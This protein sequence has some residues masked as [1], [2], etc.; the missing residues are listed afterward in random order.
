MLT[1]RLTEVTEA[2][3]QNLYDDKTPESASL[4]F[5]QELPSATPEGR[6][7]QMKDVCAL[8]NADG[9]DLIYGIAEVK[10]TASKL[11]PITSEKPDAARRRMTSVLDLIEPRIQG[12]QIQ[13]LESSSAGFFLM[14]RV[15][16][17][18]NGPHSSLRDDHLR[19]FVMRNG[20]STT[21][22]SMDQIRTAFD[23]TASL[24]DRARSFI[25]GRLALIAERKTWRPLPAGPI[26]TAIWV[27]LSGVAGR[28]SIDIA[29]LSNT[30]NQLAF[31]EWRS[32]SRTMNLDGLVVFPGGTRDEVGVGFT[33]VFRTGPMLAVRSAARLA[34]AGTSIPSTVV[35]KFY[36]EAIAKFSKESNRLGLSGP[37]IVKCALMHVDGY[38]LGVGGDWDGYVAS[39]DRPDISLPEAW[40]DAIEN[41]TTD[42]QINAIV[43]P[44]MDVL[45]QAF[46]VERCHEFALDGAWQPR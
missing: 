38:T 17:S 4:E 13:P 22:M 14:V 7:E 43:Q 27:P 24:A 39:A 28:T 9:G 29:A 5:K 16:A 3:L 8:A 36:R 31:Q 44:M 25:D 40:V 23:R 10:A 12:I 1:L 6:L 33:Q 41:V 26:A 37:A 18:F 32:I 15:P 11:M 21:D 19:R 2:Y 35:T 20:S 42:S 34:T 46:D 30:Y 45:W